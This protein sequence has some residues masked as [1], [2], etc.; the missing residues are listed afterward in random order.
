MEWQ[1]AEAFSFQFNG[2]PAL[3]RYWDAS[4]CALFLLEM[5]QSALEVELRSETEFLGRY[6]RILAQVNQHYDVRGSLLSKL[7]MMCL[8]NGGTLSL[9]RRKQFRYEAAPEVFDCIETLTRQEL[10]I[11]DTGSTPD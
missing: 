10:G 7:V 3:Y 2:H 5:T 11:A 6:D 4:E 1:D 9:N 8:D